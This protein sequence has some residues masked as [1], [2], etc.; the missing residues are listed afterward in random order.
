MTRPIVQLHTIQQWLTQD[1]ALRSFILQQIKLKDRLY[2][3]L[4]AQNKRDNELTEAKW[5]RCKRCNDSEY[6]GYVL[7]EPRY[8]GLHPSQIGHPCLLKVYNDMVG[9]PGES[10]VE[11]RLRLIFDLGHSVHHMFQ[12]YGESGAWGPVYRKEV[13][14]SGQFQELAAQLMLEGHADADNVLTIDIEGHPLYEVGIVHE[15]KTI[16]SNG[17]SKLKRPK[18][19]HK[20]QAMLYGAA[21]NRPVICYLYLN[22]DDSN[23]A[24]FPVEFE[25]ELWAQLHNKASTIKAFYDQGIPPQGEVG[26]HCKDC[27]YIFGCPAAKAAQA[28]RR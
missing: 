11:P 4:D 23:L 5:I 27:P 24:D 10:K 8:D 25:P 18:P 2:R 1:Q 3:F 13:E 12:S 19:E 17:F 26:F 15:Y 9:T 21:L 14:V 16:N 6:P 22:K 28:A 20:Q 7:L